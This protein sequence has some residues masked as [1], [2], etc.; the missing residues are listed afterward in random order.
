MD[1]IITHTDLDGVASAA[2]VVRG[3][4]REPE[5]ILFAQPHQLHAVLGK[6]R[7]GSKLYITD[8]GINPSTLAKVVDEVKRI[9][10]SGGSVRWFDHHIWDDEWIRKV[11]DAGADL[12]VDTSTCAAG[13]VSRYFPVSGPG[14]DDLV[15]ATCSIDLWVFNDWRGNFLARFVAYRKGS[16]WREEAVKKLSSF[17]GRLD[18]DTMRAAEEVIDKELKLYSKVAKE[19]E[20][21]ECRGLKIAYYFKNNDEHA[22][23]YIGNLMLS[24]FD[25]DIAVICKLKSISLRSKGFNVREL[26][27]RL[28]GGGHPR[29]SG[30]KMKPPL[31]KYLLAV[32]GIKGPLE[33]WCVSEVVKALLSMQL[34]GA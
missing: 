34:E 6:V 27:K 13:V 24:R 17:D 10:D 9:V 12:Y 19:A 25:A 20:L 28:G 2:L 15:S 7:G 8:L 29:A 26:A 14:V 30:A 33:K 5:K 21:R 31:L 3:L 11:R 18:D 32:I 22:T 4:G 16:R 1:V 23:S